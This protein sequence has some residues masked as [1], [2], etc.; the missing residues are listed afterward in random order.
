MAIPLGQQDNIG[1]KP[2]VMLYTYLYINRY[3]GTP[4]QNEKRWAS[5]RYYTVDPRLLP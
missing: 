1:E 4:D 3:A 5:P 2:T